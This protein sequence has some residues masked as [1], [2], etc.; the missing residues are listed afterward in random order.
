MR[1]AGT[2]EGAW[3]PYFV[4]YAAAHGCTPEAMRAR[5]R[6]TGGFMGWISRRWSDWH[7]RQG[8][9]HVAA[10]MAVNEAE[11]AAFEAWLPLGAWLA[12]RAEAATDA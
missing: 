7:A 3:N 2:Q 1:A 11:R 12:N 9:T 8:R 4:A 6:W 5:P 10:V